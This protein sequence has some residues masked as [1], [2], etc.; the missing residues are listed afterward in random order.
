ME[1][2]AYSIDRSIDN[3]NMV[4]NNLNKS[5]EQIDDPTMRDVLNTLVRT[6]KNYADAEDENLNGW[7]NEQ[8][9]P[10]TKVVKE[11]GDTTD[12]FDKRL[13]NLER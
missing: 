7:V 8:L 13:D 4:W 1:Y 6:L 11:L 12:K 2:K 5:L 3:D 9:D 10:L